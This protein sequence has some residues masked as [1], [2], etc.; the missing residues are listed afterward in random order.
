M[1]SKLWHYGGITPHIPIDTVISVKDVLDLLCLGNKSK[2]DVIET[3]LRS[4]LLPV[5]GLTIRLANDHGFGLMEAETD[6][7]SEDEEITD[8]EEYEEDY[9]EEDDV[10]DSVEIEDP[11]L[12]D[13]CLEI[14]IG[15]LEL[16][17]V[18]K[19]P[20]ELLRF[21]SI[22]EWSLHKPVLLCRAGF[23]LFRIGYTL[24]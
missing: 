8:E 10:V 6:T 21:I 17:A 1:I 24:S 5:A 2:W 22:S 4:V 9:D 20:D 23:F 14:T 7:V 15:K 18:V 19:D 16:Q 13:L 3:L 12:Y 11:E